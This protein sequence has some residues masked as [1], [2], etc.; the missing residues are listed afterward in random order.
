MTHQDLKTAALALEKKIAG[1]S[2]TERLSL[3]PQVRKVIL[4]M[5]ALGQNVPSRL[6]QL[7]TTLN[8]EVIESLFDNMPV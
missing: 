1:A 8:E 7:D 4:R 2:S 6:R 3:Q 5:E